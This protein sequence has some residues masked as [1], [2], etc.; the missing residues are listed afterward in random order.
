LALAA[1]DSSADTTG[2]EPSCVGDLAFAA[3]T[4]DNMWCLAF[5]G[6]VLTG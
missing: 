5:L 2:T 6:F 3:R 4:S 1:G